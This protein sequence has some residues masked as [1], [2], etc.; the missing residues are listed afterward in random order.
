MNTKAL[1]QVSRDTDPDPATCY[2]T[3]KYGTLVVRFGG[4]R[5]FEEH[6][7]EHGRR[8]VTVRSCD[9]RTTDAAPLRVNGVAYQVRAN[10]IYG[11]H[12]QWVGKD[13]EPIRVTDWY[14]R[15]GEYPYITREVHHGPFTTWTGDPTNKARRAI[16]DA[17]EQ[18]ANDAARQL[19]EAV[20]EGLRAWLLEQANAQAERCEKLRAEADE[21]TNEAALLRHRAAAL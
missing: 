1:R 5:D 3:T 21:A 11:E 6:D 15:G 16:H 20:T 7:F 19:P 2:V 9:V 10:L 13:Q 4:E 14:C 17:V 12:G 18:A 8:T